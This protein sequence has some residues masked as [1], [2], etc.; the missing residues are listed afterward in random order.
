MEKC[1]NLDSS[2]SNKI[3]EASKEELQKI[4]KLFE[5]EE[6]VSVA[7]WACLQ[8]E[9]DGSYGICN[10]SNGEPLDRTDNLEEAVI[11]ARKLSDLL[12]EKRDKRLK[13]QIH[14]CTKNTPI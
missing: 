14:E 2:T 5:T 8:Q 9:D 1:I 10:A 6:L 13:K 3:Y 7:K 4:E 11:L 12:E